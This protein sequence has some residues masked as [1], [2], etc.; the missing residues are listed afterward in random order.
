MKQ[1]FHTYSPEETEKIASEF[2]LTINSGKSEFIAMYG[3]LGVG[4]TA[5]VRGLASILAP[6]ARVKSPTFTI[7]NEYKGGKIPFYHF[8]V[9]RIN[10]DD[11][12]YAMG[13]DDYVQKGICVIEWSE[14]IPD[15]I[16]SDAYKVTIERVSD[17][18]N[19]RKI[20][21]ER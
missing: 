4:K 1:V 5:F 2:A 8:D 19:A 13:F 12:L 18:E 6:T 9:Y 3:D 17:N 7:V 16:P 11:E 20:T 15:S 10:D 14:N 21:I